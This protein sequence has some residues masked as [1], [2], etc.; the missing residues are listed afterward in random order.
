MIDSA[1]DAPPSG[2]RP[3]WLNSLCQPSITPETA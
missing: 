2:S 1:Q 3:M